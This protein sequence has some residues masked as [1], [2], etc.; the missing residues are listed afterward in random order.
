MKP[1]MDGFTCCFFN[2]FIHSSNKHLWAASNSSRLDPRQWNYSEERKNNN[3]KKAWAEGL[4]RL[5]TNLKSHTSVVSAKT[6]LCSHRA[7]FPE[8]LFL[9]VSFP[10]VCHF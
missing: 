4:D 10:K 7:P 8:K 5:K 9:H 2:A 6:L 1:L 3:N